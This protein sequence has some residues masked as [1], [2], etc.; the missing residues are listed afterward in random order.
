VIHEG[1]CTG[2]GD[3]QLLPNKEDLEEDE[4]HFGE[5]KMISK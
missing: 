3:E 4:K 2:I 1:R 5:V